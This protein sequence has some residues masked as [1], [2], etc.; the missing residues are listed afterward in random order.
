[1]APARDFRGRFERLLGDTNLSSGRARVFG[2]EAGDMAKIL[3]FPGFVL[4]FVQD[5][6]EGGKP[7][8][9]SGLFHPLPVV[10]NPPPAQ[11]F[12]QIDKPSLV[13]YGW[14]ITGE[15][16]L[17]YHRLG[18]FFAFLFGKKQMT[19]ETPGYQWVE[20]VRGLL[21]NGVTE[22]KASS[23]HEWKLLR[24]SHLG[25]SGLE[26]TLAAFWISS[27]RFPMVDWEALS[28]WRIETIQKVDLRKNTPTPA[29]TGDAQT[30]R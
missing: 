26:W 14:E 6:E 4:P 9:I 18:N 28:D 24:K 1:M 29:P 16:L 15:K 12:A 23:D 19:Q 11:L 17:Q 5:V 8:Q 20:A 27:D 25:L 10:T 30:R 22:I 13:Y 7:Y 21:G 3:F 2:D